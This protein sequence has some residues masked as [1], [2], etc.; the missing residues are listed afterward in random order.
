MPDNF[1]N[2]DYGD[3]FSAV[4]RHIEKK[5]VPKKPTVCAPKKR[6]R[7]RL[8]PLAMVLPVAV[9]AII[10]IAVFGF[11]A[12]KAKPVKTEKL[13]K[14]ET[15]TEKSPDYKAQKT[16]ATVAPDEE[17]KS[18]AVIFIDTDKNTV[19]CSRNE[20]MRLYPASTTKIMTALVACENIKDMNV[21][22]CMTAEITDPLYRADATV[23]GFVPGEQVGMLDM[24]Y[25]CILPSGADA[26][27]GI[28]QTVSGSEEAFVK[29]M[30]KK[31][32]D[33]GL[34]D[35]H[36]TNVSGLHDEQH[37]TTAY[38]MAII[39]RAAMDNPT[40]REV[41]ST[42][43]YNT[44]Q[45]E[46]HPDGIE[47][48]STL[49]SYM[50]GTEPEI[51]TIMGGKTGYTS[52]A[53]YCIASFGQSKTGNNFVCVCLKAPSKWPAMYDQINMYKKYSY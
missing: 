43:I 34:K 17:I 40:C 29:L 50:Y 21:K 42:Y 53:G 38:D 11:S 10:L 28:A 3:Y 41:L 22:F 12:K 13:V 9:I 31:V 47:L 18:E 39:I 4:E 44:A 45:T 6:K 48:F 2:K 36:F 8:R 20:N 19:V 23:A 35:T 49:F 26:A 27:I 1:G 16:A 24:L 33:L 46:Q 14:T 15:Q 37:Y 25:G 51:A 7:V 32:A 5:S 52:E 30:N